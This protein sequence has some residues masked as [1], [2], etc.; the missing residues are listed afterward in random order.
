M[1]W[2]MTRFLLPVLAFICLGWSSTATAQE[3]RGFWFDIDAG[4][5]SVRVSSDR[6]S[7]PRG[8]EGIGTLAAG[9]AVNPRLLAGVEMRIMSLDV[10][11]DIVGTADVYNVMGRVAYYPNASRG[12]FVKGAAGGSFIDLNID[13]QGTTFTAN[14]AKGLGLG[15]GVGY[16]IYL[17]RGF[18]VTPAVTY[19]YG[20][21]DGLNIFGETYLTGWSHDVIDMTIGVSFH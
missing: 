11:G 8:W 7:G 3:R 15:A 6:E 10:T 17:G 21:M 18:S 1:R 14:I 2:S 16:D 5:G 13:Q 20:R 4:V 12:F 9:W 19:W